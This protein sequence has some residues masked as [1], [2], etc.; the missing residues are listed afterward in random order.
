M[1]L[2]TSTRADTVNP[3]RSLMKKNI[4]RIETFSPF[5]VHKIDK[6][7]KQLQLAHLYKIPPEVRSE[8]T[9]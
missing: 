9:F 8:E 3:H 5:K 2:H 7:L 6:L 4:E 1:T